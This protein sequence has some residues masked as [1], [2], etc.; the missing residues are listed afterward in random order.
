M[1]ANNLHAQTD[2]RHVTPP[3]EPFASGLG[4]IRQ[5]IEAKLREFGVEELSL[6]DTA[7]GRGR[8]APGMVIID[9]G[10]NGRAARVTFTRDE[11]ED[12]SHCVDAYCVQRKIDRLVD[13]LLR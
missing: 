6:G 7:R 3:E 9:V 8:S 4:N 2:P 12:C 1:T 11:V 10:A 13:E 5:A